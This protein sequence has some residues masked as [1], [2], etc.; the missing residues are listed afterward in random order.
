MLK[1]NSIP[2]KLNDERGYSLLFGKAMETEHRGVG[3]KPSERP[4]NV[5]WGNLRIAYILSAEMEEIGGKHALSLN[6]W[7]AVL[8]KGH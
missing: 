1:V 2:F 5:T 8:L 7:M 3:D 4:V 6:P